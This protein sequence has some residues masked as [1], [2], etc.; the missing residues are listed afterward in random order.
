M[1]NEFISDYNLFFDVCRINTTKC[2]ENVPK[3][4]PPLDWYK[5]YVNVP[6]WHILSKYWDMVPLVNFRAKG[7]G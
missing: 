3:N 6:I 2:V 7:F 1:K 4:V 5:S